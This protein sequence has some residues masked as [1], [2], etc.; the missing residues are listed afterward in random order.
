M[1]NKGPFIVEAVRFLDNVLHRMDRHQSKKTASLEPL[2]LW[3]KPQGARYTS[4][5]GDVNKEKPLT[6]EEREI[7]VPELG[8]PNRRSRSASHSGH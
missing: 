1:L 3:I 7:E 8:T 5:G 2:E 6:L 4:K